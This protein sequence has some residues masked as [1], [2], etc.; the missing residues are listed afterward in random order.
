MFVFFNH[1]FTVQRFIFAGHAKTLLLRR[2]VPIIFDDFVKMNPS[3]PFPL[4]LQPFVTTTTASDIS[5]SS[6]QCAKKMG[7]RHL[8]AA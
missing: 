7:S 1:P 8:A 3:L 2:R 5:G 6:S 4:H